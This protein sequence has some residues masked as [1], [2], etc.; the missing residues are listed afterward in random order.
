ML[1]PYH[2]LLLMPY[3]LLGLLPFGAKAYMNGTPQNVK[4]EA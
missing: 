4:V 3:F 2:A 1:L